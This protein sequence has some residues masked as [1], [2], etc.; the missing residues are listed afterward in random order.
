MLRQLQLHLAIALLLANNSSVAT[1]QGVQAPVDADIL[2][3]GGQL[4]DGSGS[5]AVPGDVAIRGDRIVAVG[6]FQPGSNRKMRRPGTETAVEAGRRSS[7]G[8][9]LSARTLSVATGSGVC[10]TT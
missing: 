9:G 2:L 6:L 7:S 10:S 5:P 8:G 1:A 3:H 4:L